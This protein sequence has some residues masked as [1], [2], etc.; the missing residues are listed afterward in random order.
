MND[1]TPRYDRRNVHVGA[2]LLSVKKAVTGP[3]L[4]EKKAWTLAETHS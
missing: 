4:K 1:E 2:R 3:Y